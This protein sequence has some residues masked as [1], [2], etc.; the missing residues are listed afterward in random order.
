MMAHKLCAG[1]KDYICGAMKRIQVVC[2][3]REKPDYQK[4]KTECNLPVFINTIEEFPSL[5]LEEK[6]T[7]WLIDDMSEFTYILI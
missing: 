1:H 7:I 3:Y 4:L 5:K 2:A 6:D